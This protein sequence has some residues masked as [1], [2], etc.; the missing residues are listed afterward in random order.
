MISLQ[1]LMI[2]SLGR[3]IWIR[4][5]IRGFMGLSK[6]NNAQMLQHIL[7]IGEFKELC[8]NDKLYR[9]VFKHDCNARN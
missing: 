2:I 5:L 6:P 3:A 4:S 7:R 8:E 1:D 9:N